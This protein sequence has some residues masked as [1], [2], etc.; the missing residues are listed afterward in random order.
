MPRGAVGRCRG[1]CARRHPPRIDP[2]ARRE[3]SS[4]GRSPRG[5]DRARRL[6][7][8]MCEVGG[9]EHCPCILW[10]RS[11]GHSLPSHLASSARR[12]LPSTAAVAGSRRLRL[13]RRWLEP[14]NANDEPT[15]MLRRRPLIGAGDGAS[16]EEVSKRQPRPRVAVTEHP[17][18][19][20]PTRR[21]DRRYLIHSATTQLNLQ[22]LF[23]SGLS[24]DVRSVLAQA[25]EH[26]LQSAL[27]KAR[28]SHPLS[29]T[30]PAARRAKQHSRSRLW[31]TAGGQAKAAVGQAPDP[32]SC[33]GSSSAAASI[34]E[35]DEP[36]RSR[37]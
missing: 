13:R 18:G 9:F 19:I 6:T 28:A 23:D 22:E 3:P 30:A 25:S 17:G 16:A 31:R 15:A 8:R 29:L 35:A 32:P 27:A 12:G 2:A 36:G 5:D 7:Q 21:L 14:L 37:V 34:E 20:Q 10:L 24:H 11:S 33:I 4:L 26:K 1:N